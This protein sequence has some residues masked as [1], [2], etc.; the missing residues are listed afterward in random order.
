M[1]ERDNVERSG[2]RVYNCSQAA[3]QYLGRLEGLLL[4]TVLGDYISSV[5]Y[6]M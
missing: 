2:S 6:Y 5:R 4:N 3:H 1:G